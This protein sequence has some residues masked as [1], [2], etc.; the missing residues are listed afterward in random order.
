MRRRRSFDKEGKLNE[1]G[2]NHP[3]HEECAYE[4]Q[5]ARLRVNQLLK[6][7]ERALSR[8]CGVHPGVDCG[9]LHPSKE[10]V[11]EDIPTVEMRHEIDA[12]DLAMTR[13]VRNQ[14][15]CA[16]RTAQVANEV[17]DAGDLIVVLLAHANVGE[18][19]DRGEDR[20]QSTH[21]KDPHP[22]SA[23]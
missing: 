23:L 3:E 8:T 14:K 19:A 11:K 20:G 5:H 1:A 15:R 17:A 9:L 13:K 7:R 18:R 6:L 4:G 16:D 2:D 22:P 12:A 21:P 10:T